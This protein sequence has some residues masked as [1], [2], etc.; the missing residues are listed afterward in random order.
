MPKMAPICA[1]RLRATRSRAEAHDQGYIELAL[2]TATQGN[3]NYALPADLDLGAY[4]SV[5]IYCQA[6][7]V[8]FSTATLE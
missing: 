7:H 2:L 6:F 1:S 8:V 4:K 5:V 3:Q